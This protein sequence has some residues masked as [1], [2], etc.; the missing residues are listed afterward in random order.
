MV[1]TPCD[2]NAEVL[3]GAVLRGGAQGLDAFYSTIQGK[4]L[5]GGSIT[6]L[7]TPGRH[8]Q[9]HPQLHLLAPSGG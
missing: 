9:Y 6:V 3:W 5:Q 4:A 1:R 2:Q 8:G 7:H